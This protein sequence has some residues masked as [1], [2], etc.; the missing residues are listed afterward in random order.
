M[1]KPAGELPACD[2]GA[3]LSTAE[4]NVA[5]DRVANTALFRASRRRPFGQV[6][7]GFLGDV[8]SMRNLLHGAVT[9]V[10][11]SDLLEDLRTPVVK[12]L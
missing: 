10:L 1:P 6:A 12:S 3:T 4:T 5:A 7:A 9:D 2:N 8:G 11:R